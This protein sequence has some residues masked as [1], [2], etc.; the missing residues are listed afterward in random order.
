[1]KYS[2]TTDHLKDSYNLKKKFQNFSERENLV[3]SLSLIQFTNDAYRSY[4]Q[5]NLI[6]FFFTSNC[7]YGCI[8][9]NKKQIF[10]FGE[11]SKFSNLINKNLDKEEHLSIHKISDKDIFLKQL[12][13]NSFGEKNIN[14]FYSTSS[15]KE[16]KVEIFFIEDKGFKLNIESVEMIHSLINRYYLCLPGKIDKQYRNFFGEFENL[17]LSQ[18]NSYSYEKKTGVIANFYIQDLGPYFTAMGEYRSGEIL[19]EVR[20]IILSYL[21]KGDLLYRLSHQSFLT[22]SYECD[23]ES[24]K[25]R[26]DDVYFQIKNLIVDYEIYFYPVTKP[27]HSTKEFWQKIFPQGLI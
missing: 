8:Y 5:K 9:E 13:A 25:H 7:I 22:Y 20:L 19:E 14:L 18:I 24:M 6:Y 23:I 10:E 27:I 11:N 26:F 15:L 16:S 21:K 12:N 4:F 2:L 3:H 17:F 1:M